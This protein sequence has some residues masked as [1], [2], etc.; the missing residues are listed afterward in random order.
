MLLLHKL[1]QNIKEK[2]NCQTNSTKPELAGY[3]NK[4]GLPQEKNTIDQYP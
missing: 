2:G 3:Q 4:V 1:F